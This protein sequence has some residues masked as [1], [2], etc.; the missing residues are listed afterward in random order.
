MSKGEIVA[1][2]SDA[3][4]S[5]V[6]TTA[7]VRLPATRADVAAPE[8][9]LLPQQARRSE[10]VKRVLGALTSLGELALRVLEGYGSQS[11]LLDHTDGA[12]PLTDTGR[13]QSR[14]PRAMG[15]RR[16]R[17]RGGSTGRGSP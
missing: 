15:G 3:S 5:L 17:H 11:D 6:P 12:S 4:V 13:S 9:D 2:Q 7:T 10:I 14:A 1:R 16:W 8:G